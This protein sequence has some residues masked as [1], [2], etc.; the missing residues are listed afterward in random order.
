MNDERPL[1]GVSG[2]VKEPLF[3]L[4]IG[5]KNPEEDGGPGIL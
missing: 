3:K 1:Q 4:P 2:Q 5:T